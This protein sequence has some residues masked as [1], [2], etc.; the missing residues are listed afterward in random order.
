[1]SL[2]TT[3]VQYLTDTPFAVGGRK[4]TSRLMVG[5]GKYADNATMVAALDASGAEVVTVAV[6]RVDLD[7]L[8]FLRPDAKRDG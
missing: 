7:R 5:T 6:R 4:F 3:D 8:D 1:M 2:M